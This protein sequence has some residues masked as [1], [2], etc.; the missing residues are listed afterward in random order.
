MQNLAKASRAIHALAFRNRYV[1]RS[2]VIATLF[3]LPQL[4]QAQSKPL[5]NS[6]LRGRVTDARTKEPLAGASIKIEGVTN[7]TQTDAEGR[8]TLITGQSFPYNLLISSIGYQDVKVTANGSPLTVE[9]TEAANDL[10]GVVVVGY[11]TRKRGDVTG[12]IASVSQ[13]ALKQPVSS[14][15]QALKGA[16]TGVQVTQTSGQPGG[17]VSIRIRGGA[18]I[19]GGNEP[20]YVVDGFPLYNSAAST[21]A[22]S[23]TPTN[24]LASINPADIESVDI[25]KDASATAIYGSRGANGVVIITTKKG[26][27]DRNNINFETS[28]GMQTVRKKIDVLGAKDFAILR[29]EVLY[30]TTPAA[31]KYQYLSQQQIDQLGEGT[32]WQNAAFRKAPLQSHQLSV[33]GGSAKVQ[34]LLSGNYY[35]QEGI[36][37]NTDFSRLSLRANVDARPGDHLKTG[38]SLAISGSKANIAPSGIIGSLL[39]MP[40]TATIYEPDGS[41]TLRNPFENIFANP[42]ATLNE[43]SNKSN[44]NRLLGTAYAEYTIAR[45][46]AVKVLAGADVSNQKDKY[47]V[48]SAIYEGAGPKGTASLGSSNYNSWLNENTITYNKSFGKHAIDALAG[49]TQQEAT[50]ESFIAGAQNFVS[51]DLTYNNLGSGA[52]LV[53]PA[54]D[55]YSWVLHSYLGRVNYSY[56]NLYYLTASI[57][58]DGSSRFGKNNKWGNFPSLAASWKISNEDFFKPLLKHVTDLKIR[59]SFGTTGNLEI[60]QYQSLSTLYS[61]NYI[62]G[63]SILTGFAPNRVPNDNLGWETTYQYDAGIDV[64]LFSNRLLV[65]L[66]AYYKKT[67][68]LLLNVEIPWTTGYASSLQNFGSVENKGLELG[69]KTKNIVRKNFSWETDLNISFNRN[70]VLTIGNGASSYIS[71]NYVIQVGQPLGTFY[72]TITD[73]ILQTGEETAKGKFTGSATPKPGDRLYK[74]VSGDG[75]FTTAADRAIIGNAQPDFIYGI[76]N[77]LSWKG[78]DLSVLLQGVYGNQI[79]NSN[80]QTL[81]MF[82]GQQNASVT[83]LDRWTETNPSTTIPRAKLDPAPIFSDRFVEDGSFLRVKNINL[84]YALPK[85]LLT[86]A[87]LTAVSVFVSAQ[88]LLTFTKYTGFDPEVTS[89]SNVSPGTDSGIYPVAKTFNAGLR[90]SF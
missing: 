61:L 10:N 60:G 6:T 22:L 16:A 75:A 46:L 27:A 67:N 78:F 39:I 55:T 84:S 40:P 47:Y 79:I 41:Y 90:V 58:R 88:N 70:K 73:G 37:K 42:I 36:I 2:S 57:R 33:S 89:G 18:S 21:G 38:V 35:K 50:N 48:P 4:L 34:Y 13:A 85:T 51:D 32:N 19:Q 71:G 64:G 62:F 49:F 80:R 23:G 81:E 86:K 3:F 72:G 44:I 82:T 31:G 7:Q 14:L 45:N 20:L 74:D 25:L 17:G 77:N 26:K 56:N 65:S 59:S 52:T 29:N 15:D 8:F 54:S 1:L 28:Y 11:G 66:D 5:I 83:A 63:G 43:T 68:D 76:I 12:A 87:N 69:I 53:R 24:P 30:S 9:L